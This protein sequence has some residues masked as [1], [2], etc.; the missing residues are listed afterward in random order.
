MKYSI[1]LL[2]LILLLIAFASAGVMNSKVHI[3][4]INAD[5]SQETGLNVLPPISPRWVFEPWVWED[6]I[7][8]QQATLDL[9]IGYLDRDIPVAAVIID[10]PW[11]TNYNTFQFKP[12]SYPEAQGL[13]DSLNK[14][15][16]NVILWITGCLV[17]ESPNYNYARQSGFFVRQ[18]GNDDPSPTTR[19]WK[20]SGRASHIDFFNPHAISWWHTLMDQVLN[21]GV[22]GWKTD[23]S[24]F[25][26]RDLGDTIVTF[27]GKKSKEEYSDA[28]YRAFYEYTTQKRGLDY[29]MIMARPYAVD[30]EAPYWHAPIDVNTAGWV[31]DQMHTWKGLNQAL[32]EMFISVTAGYATVGSDI[33]GYEGDNINKNLLIRW[34]QLGAMLPIMENGGAGEHRPWKYDKE[35]ENI[36]RYFAKL[37]HQLVPYLYSYDIEASRTGVSIVRPIGATYSEWKND[38]RYFLGEYFFISPIYD[39]I[40][41]RQVTFPSEGEWINYWN[42]RQVYQSGVTIQHDLPLSQFPI[43]IRSGAIIPMNVEDAE[44]GHGTPASRGW[45]TLLIY[46]KDQSTFI[47]HK[48]PNT[49]ILFESIH[50]SDSL[51]FTISDSKEDYIFRIKND[52]KPATVKLQG[53]NTLENTDSLGFENGNYRW[54]FDSNKGLAW[55]KFSTDGNSTSL[56]LDYRDRYAISGTTVYYQESRPVSNAIF[57]LRHEEGNN[58]DTT[59][60]KGYYNFESIVTGFAELVPVKVGDQRNAIRGSDAILLLKYLMLLNDL[61]EDQKFAA[62]VTGDSCLTGSDA[63]AIL[64]YLAFFTDSIGSTG[65]WRFKPDTSTLMLSADTILDFKAYLQGDVNGDWGESGEG[66]KLAIGLPGKSSN[67]SIILNIEDISVINKPNLTLLIRIEQIDKPIHTLILT[68]NYDHGWLQYRSTEKTELRHE[69]MAVTNGK[70]PGKVHIAMADLEGLDKDG[71]VLRLLFDVVNNPVQKNISGLEITRA[72]INDLKVNHVR[73]RQIDFTSFSITNVINHSQ[74]IQNYPNPFNA[75]TTFYY[76]LNKDGQVKLS[77]Y[78]ILGELIK[79]VESAY[80]PAGEYRIHWNGTNSWGVPVAS[81]GYFYQIRFNQDEVKIGKLLLVR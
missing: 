5:V 63:Q 67:S 64:R 47:F 35:T 76:K 6:N 8:T 78:N 19:F 42:E 10:S 58:S 25:L 3:N 22:N 20:G 79:T 62:D 31:G 74:S 61:T 53:Y 23:C 15:G 80:Q 33:G 75:N 73:D 45:L 54:Y 7:N 9:V 36:Y 43:F 69:F 26:V 17:P 32:N 59:D 34:A 77:I 71:D 39:D 29:G 60:V 41:S 12:N 68:L 51:I 28:Y 49:D 14:C 72:F 57:D 44:T 40:F 24:D 65:Q 46:P 11:E 27:K 37:H 18:I 50:Q 66:T 38:W 2:I 48:N 13:I 16:V 21:M 55:V 1:I 52:C 70:E 30:F 4:G 56:T 81:G